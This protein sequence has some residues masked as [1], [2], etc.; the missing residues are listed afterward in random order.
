M[1]IDARQRARAPTASSSARSASLGGTRDLQIEIAQT[2]AA[3]GL[4]ELVRAGVARRACAS[5]PYLERRRSFA[6]APTPDASRAAVRAAFLAPPVEPAARRSL[7][8]LELGWGS[9]REAW[10][11]LRDLPPATAPPRR[12]ATSPSAPRLTS[13]WLMARDALVAVIDWRCRTEIALRA[14]EAALHGGDAASALALARARGRR[15]E[16]L[17]PAPRGA[18]ALV[19]VRALAALGRAAERRA[20]ADAYARLAHARPARCG[21]ARGRVG[22]GARR[23]MRGRARRSPSPGGRGGRRGTGWLALYEGDLQDRARVAARGRRSTADAVMA[24][25]LPL[26]HARRRSAPLVGRRSSRSRAA[27]ARRPRRVRGVRARARG[28]VAAAVARRAHRAA[29]GDAGAA[30]RALAADRRAAPRS[31]EAAEADLEWAR[32]LRS[33]RRSRARSQRLEH[34][35]LTDPQS[36]LVPQA[37]ASSSSRAGHSAEH[38]CMHA[39]SI[40][41]SERRAGGRARGA[42]GRSSLLAI[43]RSPRAQHL[44]VPMDDAQH[45]PPQGVRSHV[46][47]AQDGHEGRVAAELSRRLVPAARYA[48]AAAARR[49]RRHH[50]S[51]RSTTARVAAIR[52][53]IAGEQHGGG[54]AGEGAEDRGLHAAEGAA[55]G[56]RRDA[57]AQVR[58]HRVHAIWD[59]EV[60]ARRPDEVRLAAPAPRGLHRPAQQ[61]LPRL[62][63]RALVRRAA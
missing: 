46:Q 17:A 40:A 29:R 21:S 44:L 52:A 53:E 61:V 11:A 14:A 48:G 6:L 33:Q 10:A 15:V 56:R 38:A 45:E 13:A 43:P 8:A 42:R 41:A 47:R 16:R 31:P 39:T 62:S 50:R 49:A 35:I 19:Q 34:L 55:V 7:A 63:R 59:D 58:R 20:V 12:G 2:R 28:R 22:V 18:S 26:A 36:A 23:R 51:S 25:A 24:L 57:R 27:T 30:R 4:W 54:A 3:L 1:L 60:V 37:G 9:P 5:A 32:A